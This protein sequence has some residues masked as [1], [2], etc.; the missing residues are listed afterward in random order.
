MSV[1]ST[2]WHHIRRSPF[3]SV[4]AIF[5]MTLSFF[6]LTSFIIVSNGLSQVLRY[7]ENKPEITLFLKDGL[8][9]PTV[10]GIEKEISQYPNIKSIKFISKDEALSIYRDQNKDN[11]LLLEMVNA[12]ILPA[13][14]EVSAYDP[15]T[16]ELISQNFAS[17]KTQ[18]DEI[19]Y[20]KDVVDSLLTWTTTIRK[21]GLV[22]ISV[23]GFVSF[24][25]IF[26]V[27]TMKITN[28]KEEIRVSRLLG[29]SNWYVNRPFLLEGLFYGIIG[30]VFGSL[31]SGAIFYFTRNKINT[32]FTPVNF[33]S[34]DFIYLAKTM[35][36][37]LAGAIF[38]G[39]FASWTGVKRLIKF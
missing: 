14:F 29:A 26:T 33:F 21:V 5:I 24:L 32:F 20:Q 23:L 6:V 18:I 27:I 38:V 4:G 10:E 16:L 15:K 37:E 7:F 3:Q 39:L 19:V 17:R 34:F 35:A 12:N 11:P 13:S 28:R 8:D 2:T 31:I 25:F 30:M 9:K 1:L 36:V 22:I